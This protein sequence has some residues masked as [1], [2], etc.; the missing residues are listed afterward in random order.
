MENQ[1]T[2]KQLGSTWPRV[3]PQPSTWTLAESLCIYVCVCVCVCV[4]CVCVGVC[5]RVWAEARCAWHAFPRIAEFSQ[6]TP[7]LSHKHLHAVP[8]K[9]SPCS[10]HLA[11]WRVWVNT[12]PGPEYLWN[13][14]MSKSHVFFVV[15]DVVV[16]KWKIKHMLWNL[17]YPSLKLEV[18]AMQY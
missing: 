6:I 17:Q 18:L 12:T 1:E 15:N 16:F 4:V 13:T 9:G 8:K 14:A 3:C 5:M 11:S 10:C 2:A 7:N